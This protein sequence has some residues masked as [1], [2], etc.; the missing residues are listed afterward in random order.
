MRP[1]RALEILGSGFLAHPDNDRLRD[2][3]AS[4]GLS[5]EDF[6]RQLR[7]FAY[8]IVLERIAEGAWGPD[9]VRWLG[10]APDIAVATI[11]A[12]DYALAVAELAVDVNRTDELGRVHE[13]FVGLV[14]ELSVED[15]AFRLTPRKGRK[16]AGAYYT[17][18]ILVD[19]LLDQSLERLVETVTARKSP[20]EAERDLLTLRILDPAVG[21]GRFLVAAARRLARRVTQLRASRRVPTM[22]AT[23]DVVEQCLYG[24]DLDPDSI[25]VAKVALWL[26][27]GRAPRTREVLDR[28]LKVGNSLVGATEEWVA[29]GIPDNA[30]DLRNDDDISLV[31]QLRTQ[32]RNE[33]REFALP[34]LVDPRLAYDAWCAA[35]TMEKTG[36]GPDPITSAHLA[37]LTDEAVNRYAEEAEGDALLSTVRREALRH[38][39]F[40][41]PLEFP[42]LK[43]DLVV[44]NPPFVNAISRT[45]EDRASGIVNARTPDVGGA[46]DL[47]FRFLVAASDW[48]KPGGWIAF[49]QPRAALNALPLEGFRN[50][51]PGGLQPR[52]VGAF[53]R[54]DLFSSASIYVSVVVLGP[55]GECRVPAPTGNPF[56]D[57]VVQ[58]EV[59]TNWFV[60]AQAPMPPPADESV[61]EP[62]PVEV[63]LVRE[64]ASP[65]ESVEPPVEPPKGPATVGDRFTVS[66]SMTAADAYNVLPF[67]KDVEKGRGQRLVTTGLIEPGEC[68]WGK[69]RCRYLKRV[70]QFPRI[71]DAKNLPP[72]IR[73]RWEAS[74]RPKV[75]VAGLAS[76]L[77][78][79]LDAEGRYQ[80]AVSTYSI[81]HPE[82]DVAELRRLCDF[83]NSPESSQRLR[84]ELGANAL[85]GGSITVKKEWLKQLAFE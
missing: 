58:N 36:H 81:F 44:G 82:N 78:A 80:G 49:V 56:K 64:E 72:T 52:F 45:H 63:E 85:G 9:V 27:C 29:E 42:G 1:E 35:H 34:P 62:R 37:S 8:R 32:N 22:T 6:T 7:L 83:L 67:I 66:A 2:R 84:R 12:E 39:F 13:S 47:A 60:A 43:F 71:V 3:L 75:V 24:V 11:A 53:D 74:H 48:V 26:E 46:A 77:E 50:A 69:D 5:P 70:F 14:P 30:Y 28:H 76:R 38:R 16:E 51:P 68:L 10:D 19:C 18:E 25:G 40:H 31:R 21:S 79:F 65:E 15:G 4:G 73:R 61:T 23:R 41:W 17:P 59:P 33:R 57:W 20:D 55:P 54:P